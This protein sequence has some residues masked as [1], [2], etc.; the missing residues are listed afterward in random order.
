MVVRRC[1][2]LVLAF[3]A[4]TLA[5]GCRVALPTPRL[6][7][8]CSLNENLSSFE[9]QTVTVDAEY[10]EAL[11]HGIMLISA[12]CGVTLVNQKGVRP[13]DALTRMNLAARERADGFYLP[14]GR[15]T[16]TI[17]NSRSGYYFEL[18]DVER[19]HLVRATDP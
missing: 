13:N 7:S 11:P 10:V 5:H 4:L 1:S 6:V 12:H 19:L 17:R 2:I 18:M 16:G 15:F 14:F 3:I 8:L 9:G